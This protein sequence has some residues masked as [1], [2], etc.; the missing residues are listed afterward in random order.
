[1]VKAGTSSGY[2][3]VNFING[4]N[5]AKPYRAMHGAMVCRGGKSVNLGYYATAEEAAVCRAGLVKWGGCGR[6]SGVHHRTKRRSGPSPQGRIKRRHGLCSNI[7]VDSV[8]RWHLHR[9]QPRR[10]P[11]QHSP[12]RARPP[13]STISA[14]RASTPSWRSCSLRTVSGRCCAADSAPPTAMHARARR[15]TRPSAPR[16]DLHLRPV[17]AAL[18]DPV[19]RAA[20]RADRLT[21]CRG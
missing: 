13:T 1:M 3:G 10:K 8:R 9:R 12:R 17:G 5:V 4:K 7:G 15:L 16:A 18:H 2:K 6:S 11:T 19:G 21:R 14:S 20:P